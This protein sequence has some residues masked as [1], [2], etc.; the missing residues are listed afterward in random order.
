MR[1]V[2]RG[3]RPLEKL[4]PSWEDNIQTDVKEAQ[5]RN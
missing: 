2:K 3:K 5:D 1:V 4:T